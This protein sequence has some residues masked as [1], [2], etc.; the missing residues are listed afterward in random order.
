MRDNLT[1]QEYLMRSFVLY[2]NGKKAIREAPLLCASRV[3]IS[4]AMTRRECTLGRSIHY[5]IV[6]F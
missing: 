1:V 6:A 4:L 5:C 2:E 3:G